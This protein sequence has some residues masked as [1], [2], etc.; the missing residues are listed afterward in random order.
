MEV[1]GQLH[2]TGALPPANGTDCVEDRRAPESVG[3]DSGEGKN[4]L[5]LPGIEHSQAIFW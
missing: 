1:S 4:L 5:P 3:R 2:A